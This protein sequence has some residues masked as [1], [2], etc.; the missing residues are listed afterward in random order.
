[1]YFEGKLMQKLEEN[2]E[3]KLLI[4]K[5]HLTHKIDPTRLLV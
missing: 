2:L 3:E 5:A 4:G 1:M